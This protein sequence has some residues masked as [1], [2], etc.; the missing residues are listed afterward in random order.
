MSTNHFDTL[1]TCPVCE[2]ETS[3]E[4]MVR[5]DEDGTLAH[6]DCVAWAEE[7]AAE[8]RGEARREAREAAGPPAGWGA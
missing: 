5:W 7:G 8:A 1:H 4:G 3:G 6:P 2:D